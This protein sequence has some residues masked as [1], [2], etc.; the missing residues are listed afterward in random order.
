VVNVKAVV[1]DVLII[2]G[3]TFLAGF[4]IGLTG[5]ARGPNAVLAMAAG[6]L[7]FMIVGF[8]ISG[9]LARTRRFN[10]LL[11]V[12]LGV[13]LASIINVLFFGATIIQWFMSVVVI[14]AL[15]GIGGLLSYAFVRNPKPEAPDTTGVDASGET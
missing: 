11:W 15:M 5:V 13:W 12:A 8:T 3:L 6:N 2:M 14:L 7:V 10:H 4:V 1:R 9:A